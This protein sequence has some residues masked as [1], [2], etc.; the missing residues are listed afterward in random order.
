MKIHAAFD[1]IETLVKKGDLVGARAWLRK[2]RNPN[3]PNR[4]GWTPLMLAALHGRTDIARVLVEAGADPDRKKFGE[5]AEALADSKGFHR[6]AEFIK[7][8][9]R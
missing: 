1:E 6:T 5:T 2:G 4:F 8:C 9:G 7:T 3:L